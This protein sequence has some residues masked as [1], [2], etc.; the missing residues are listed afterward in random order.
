MLT[1]CWQLENDAVAFTCV[2]PGIVDTSM[3]EKIRASSHME[4]KKID[5]FKQLKEE[6]HLLL[7]ET[8]G[9]FLTWLLLDISKKDYVSQEWDIYDKTHHETWVKPP[10]V[11]WPLE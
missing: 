1:R 5:F 3:Q 7:P 9:L 6:H 4:S 10:H 2:M 11:V 8:V